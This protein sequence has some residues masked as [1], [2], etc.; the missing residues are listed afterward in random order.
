MY[1]SSIT[2]TF[3]ITLS[4][5]R[6]QYIKLNAGSQPLAGR[7]IASLFTPAATI[8]PHPDSSRHISKDLLAV[9][10]MLTHIGSSSTS[11]AGAANA[12]DMHSNRTVEA[13]S[14]FTSTRD[15]KLAQVKFMYKSESFR[16]Q[17]WNLDFVSLSTAW[18]CEAISMKTLRVCAC[19]DPASTDCWKLPC[20]A[21]CFN[22]S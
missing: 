11:N 5:G 12:A 21:S 20:D 16:R 2:Q 6:S 22:I 9:S 10:R 1:H 8:Q 4:N 17:I 14:G 19:A 15:S 7:R 13:S 18:V 3:L